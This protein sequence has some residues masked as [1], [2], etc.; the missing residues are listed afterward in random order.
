MRSANVTP[1]KAVFAPASSIFFHAGERFEKIQRVSR[2]LGRKKIAH[3]AHPSWISAHGCR[4]AHFFAK[5]SGF[6]SQV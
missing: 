3:G 2:E 4:F 1:N 5:K 6:G